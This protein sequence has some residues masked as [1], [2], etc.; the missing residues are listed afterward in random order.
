MQRAHDCDMVLVHDDDLEKI[1]GVDR[2]R[3]SGHL[4]TIYIVL[5]ILAVSELPPTRNGDGSHSGFRH[6]D[7]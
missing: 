5:T 1:D 4:V 6:K 3:V 7:T 2:G